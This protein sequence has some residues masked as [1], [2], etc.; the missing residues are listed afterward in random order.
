[1]TMLKI[2]IQPK[3]SKTVCKA[4][5]VDKKGRVLLLKRTEYMKKFANTWDLPGG[6][7]HVGE[8]NV[9]GLRREVKEETDLDLSDVKF[10]KTVDGRHFFLCK[11]DKFD[12]KL[13]NEHS[14]YLFREVD[15]LDI[16]NKFEY[17]AKE[18]LQN[19]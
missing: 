11:V 2:L 5:I 1:M 6:H 8:S 13:S 3:D 16:D 17:I 18:I 9:D 4:I 12:I 15:D 19:E 14:E 7:V 10:A